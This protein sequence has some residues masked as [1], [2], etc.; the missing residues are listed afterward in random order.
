MRRGEKE[1]HI[2]QDFEL[3]GGL[4]IRDVPDV[5][6]T[7]VVLVAEEAFGVGVD[8][9]SACS[10]DR[11]GKQQVRIGIM[12]SVCCVP[13][14]CFLVGEGEVLFGTIPI[15]ELDVEIGN[16][17]VSNSGEVTKMN[18]KRYVLASHA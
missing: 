13:V 7:E 6:N 18:L 14:E 9:I 10:C 5:P 16:V 15:R 4:L 11:T 1:A 3:D 2:S 12:D 8:L 17:C